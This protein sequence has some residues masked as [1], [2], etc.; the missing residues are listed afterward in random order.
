VDAL[1]IT[2]EAEKG[3]IRIRV[4]DQGRGFEVSPAPAR[5]ATGGFGLMIVRARLGQLG[6]NLYIESRA[7][8]GTRATIILPCA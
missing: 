3:W 7:G 5:S 4:V 2:C 8:I 6:G 1:R